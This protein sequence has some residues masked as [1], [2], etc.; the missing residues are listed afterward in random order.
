MSHQDA[1]AFARSIVSRLS[2]A[3]YVHSREPYARVADKAG[4]SVGTLH[5]A[6]DPDRARRTKIERLAGIAW[7]LGLEFNFAMRPR[8]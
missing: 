7:A 8:R 5:R 3:L 4:I 2:M 6:L 1:E